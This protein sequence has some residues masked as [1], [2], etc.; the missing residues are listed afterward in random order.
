MS[1][2][3]QRLLKLSP[4]RLALLALEQQERLEALEGGPTR[5]PIAVI[6]LG[7]RFPGASGPEAYWELLRDGVDAVAEITSDRWDIDEYY[8]PDPDMPGRMATRWAGL[9]DG[10]DRFDPQ[11][12]GISPREARAMDPQQRLLL[13]V[14]W[15]ALE[16][17]GIA[18][19]SLAATSTGT[20]VGACNAD[21]AQMLFGGDGRDLDM[22]LATGNADSVAS[23]RL[24]YVMGL[25]GPALTVDTACS[26]SLVATH[27]AVQGLR[28]GD[29][30]LALAGGVNAILSA[31]TTIALSQAKMMAADGRC[32]AF[33]AAAD[34]FVRG[35]GCGLLVLKRL[36]DAERDGDRVLAVIRGSAVNQDGRSNGLT[37][38]N[39]PS[40]I[41]VIRAA[42]ADGS[43]EPG[44]VG[45][46]EAH[47]TGTSLGDPI[48]IQALGAALG[49]G[50][51]PG[52]RLLVGSVK[53]NL[54]HLESAAGVAGLIKL[55]LSME[56]G[57]V[58]ASLHLH[59]PNPYIPWD[60]LPIDV[61]TER[62]PWPGDGRALAG[63][64]SFG[65]SGTN[66][67]IVVEPAPADGGGGGQPTD[68]VV[69]PTRSLHLLP[70]SATDP[71]SLDALAGRYAE[72][73]TADGASL[74]DLARLAATGRTHHSHRLAVVATDGVDAA[75][76]LAAART[77]TP[78]AIVGRIGPRGPKV[79]FLFTGHGSQYPGMGAGLYRQEAVFRQAFDEC[80]SILEAENGIDLRAV[81]DPAERAGEPG[82]LAG[83][84]V[85]QPAVFAVEYAVARL[86]RSW[87]V[88]PDVVAGHSVGEYV[89]AVDAG[90]MS[91]ADG[92]R[93][94]A[95]RGRLMD[96]LP[97]GAAM[98]TVL[99]PESEVAALVAAVAPGVS[100]AAINGPASVAVSG[101]PTEVD[102]LLD[103]AKAAGVEVR[104]LD[105]PI[106]AHSPQV[107]PILDEF[108][109]IAATVSY[110]RPTTDVVSGLTGALATGDDLVTAYYWRR[111]LRQPV[112]FA[113]A[114]ATVH[115]MGARAHIET[116]PHPTLLNM[117]RHIVDE[118]D[119]TWL[120]SLRRG[121]DD[122][123]IVLGSLGRLY[124]I[125]GTID[126]SA[127]TG[128]RS[129]VVTGP[130]YPFRRD[131]HWAAA[132][133]GIDHGRSDHPLVG[134]RLD[135]PALELPVFETELAATWPAWLDDHRIHGTVIVPAP[136]LIEMLS[137]AATTA[138]HPAAGLEGVEIVAPLVVP[139]DGTV[140]VQ[141][142]IRPGS[143]TT[144]EV[145]SHDGS[146]GRWLTHARATIV[147][148]IDRGDG[149]ADR[150]RLDR[151][152]LNQIDGAEF[153]RDLAAVGLGFGPAFRGVTTVWTGPERAVARV[154]PS[155]AVRGDRVGYG[156]HPALLD[157]CFH[158]VGGPDEVRARGGVALLVGIERLVH[159]GPVTTAVFVEV[160]VRPTQP[161][162][163]DGSIVADLVVVDDDGR[164]LIE[165]TGVH[166]VVTDREALRRSTGRHLDDRIHEVIWESLE[167]GQGGA[168]SAVALD[169]IADSIAS[170]LEAGGVA[171]YRLVLD[172][173]DRLAEAHAG[174]A[175]SQLGD[176]AVVDRHRALFDHLSSQPRSGADPE[177]VAAEFRGRHP[178]EA[179]EFDLV[180]RCGRALVEVMTGRLEPLELLFPGGDQSG[181]EQLYRST[182]VAELANAV[183]ADAVAA[184]ATGR[185]LR[186]LEV[187]AG[188]G[189]T[190]DAVLDALGQA[191]TSYTMTDV[192]PTFVARAAD[193]YA[194]RAGIDCRVLDIERDPGTQGFAV[195]GYDLVIAANV[196]HA[197]TEVGATLG[198]LRR[199]LAPGGHLILLEASGQRPWVTTTFGLTEGWWRF[200]DGELR[201]D[202]PLLAGDRW[203]AALD[204]AGFDQARTL[205]GDG[206]G[207]LGQSVI[208]AQAPDDAGPMVDLVVGRPGQ[209]RQDF[210][211][212]LGESSTGAPVSVLDQVPDAASLAE[213]MTSGS[214]V[215]RL[216][217]LA[218]DLDDEAGGPPVDPAVAQSEAV[219][220]AASV[221][222][223]IQAVALAGGPTRIFAV[224]RATQP[225]GGAEVRRPH[226]AA[227][228]GL[229]RVASL[230]HPDSWGASIDL[231]PDPTAGEPAAVASLI[232]RGGD[233][234]QFA[235]RAGEVLVPR[236]APAT[237][238]PEPADPVIRADATY[239]ITGGLGG[240]GLVVADWLVDQ[241]ATSLLLLGR[242]G[243]PDTATN[244]GD[245]D[246]ARRRLAAV[247]AIEERGVRV[248]VAAVDIGDPVALAGAV[249]RC[250]SELPPLRGVIHAAAALGDRALVDL[251]LDSLAA[252]LHPKVAGTW[253]LDAATAGAPLDF[254]VSFSST[255]ALL[256]S[257]GLGHYAA[258]NAV[259][260]AHA[261]A[262]QASGRPWTSVNWGTWEVMRVATDEERATLGRGGLRPIPSDEALTQLGRIVA[263]VPPQ[264]VVVDADW[265]VLR[266]LYEARRTRPFLALV[267][268]VEQDQAVGRT[269]SVAELAAELAA[270]DAALRPPILESFLRA[271]VAAALQLDDPARVDVHQ[272]LF[273]MGMDSLM[274]VELKGQIE[275]GLGCALPSTLTFNHPTVFDLT[276]H[277]LTVVPLD[278]EPSVPEVDAD[279]NEPR[280]E[281]PAERPDGVVE[282]RAELAVDPPA[283]ADPDDLDEAEL[284]AQLADRLANLLG[285]S[286][287]NA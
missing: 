64:S 1:D 245:G 54:G 144:A 271:E 99:A 238:P 187:G 85:G 84:T 52:E 90:V 177:V 102:A 66:A 69:G 82:P 113:D 190:T 249:D 86:W 151:S 5:E 116:G 39:G 109:R 264:L 216:I 36:A 108:E 166:L 55:V 203:L 251:D 70:V 149:R 14:A 103:A 246:E 35:E 123:A 20:Y 161:G 169:A 81:L 132:P 162:A 270:A 83:M 114:F 148:E 157:A 165:A 186:I 167:S 119:G 185:E 50:R 104:P 221:L 236:L 154:E 206:D 26:S 250:G 21:Y 139:D 31:K 156:V 273:E 244:D 29:C 241:G 75:E 57:E 198:H 133:S 182:P 73:V 22:Y 49:E 199:L 46:V 61:A 4:E 37:A 34:G 184:L 229:G 178:T 159:H 176:G 275:H 287:G 183:V 163:D 283:T 174:V 93:L 194:G 233:H 172:D 192:A 136:A 286:E 2:L 213:R 237:G 87:G 218:D 60:R 189:A 219:D 272:G 19:D 65:F 170:R 214:T 126:W 30:D 255:T 269:G 77:E 266:P 111:H 92:L 135:S 260:D 217:V 13:E 12:F 67:H 122:L 263:A 140:R 179:T 276:N 105:I 53:T 45:Y 265:Q 274:S 228:W 205:T 56:H 124:T 160:I 95:A 24:A 220:A 282:S 16:H 227:V 224:T 232:G 9:V 88:V 106:A 261:N 134:S 43:V 248:E 243:L 68:A 129:P 118:A 3:Y 211:D 277:L 11:F 44:E 204:A 280:P 239:L 201:S 181:A 208:T 94:V 25:Q 137:G 115:E 152:G 89:A 100:V 279:S 268:A 107:E 80:A 252:M 138:G 180:D 147:S 210:V 97:P 59:E 234:D 120:P 110:H 141:T 253:A 41:S 171:G 28:A 175:L 254:A 6:G 200:T 63:V 58:P 130:A 188:T 164:L 155:D 191:A 79:S 78:G 62:R 127:V 51:G 15:H 128:H 222:T 48:E 150:D 47:G 91:L 27:L 101:S 196:V 112:R 40:Q 145:V 142:L 42:L 284:E 33:D 285:T 195:G 207:L 158:A 209:W 98:A 231:A 226:L 38:P 235:L 146:S 121:H 96:T 168:D 202:G 240:L 17:A 74:P 281:T 76:A 230:E 215:G 72:A 71:E 278:G 173:L 212:A 117:G 259:L 258:A 10:I 143:T 131:R 242:R 257:A 197:T 125:G 8:D 247:R 223:A 32:K 262:T 18:P 193:R 267:G 23:G 256:G 225:A 7:C 153:Y